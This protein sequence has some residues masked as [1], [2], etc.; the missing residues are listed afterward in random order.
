MTEEINKPEVSALYL[1]ANK[2]VEASNILRPYNSIL[3][4]LVLM[5]GD[6][7]ISDLMESRGMEI[8]PSGE[9][10]RLDK[11]NVESIRSELSDMIETVKA[12]VKEEAE[13]K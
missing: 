9:V 4:K 3:S 11:E 7:I 13:T 1:A 6:S 8:E 2:L 5:M 12:E 10:N